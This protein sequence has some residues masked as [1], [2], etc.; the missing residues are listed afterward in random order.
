MEQIYYCGEC[1]KTFATPKILIKHLK[2]F[3]RLKVNSSFTCVQP[4]CK[5]AAFSSSYTFQKHLNTHQQDYEKNSFPNLNTNQEQIIETE[6]LPASIVLPEKLSSDE[7][8][9]GE[10]ETSEL[11][12][13]ELPLPSLSKKKTWQHSPEENITSF[14]SFLY[15]KTQISRKT[16]QE[17][18]DATSDFLESALNCLSE[19]CKALLQNQNQNDYQE[20]DKLI[21]NYLKTFQAFTTE[22]KRLSLFSKAT[23]KFIPPVSV[24]I[25]S[26]MVK[27]NN[28]EINIISKVEVVPLRPTLKAF[29]EMPEMLATVLKYMK[30][31]E[32]SE[33]LYVSSFLSSR[34][35]KEIKTLFGGNIVIPMFL[36]FD[37]YETCNPLGSKKTKHKMGGVYLQLACL[38]PE[39]KSSLKNTFLAQIFRSSDRCH[40]GNARIFGVLIRLLKDLEENGIDFL[41][42]GQPIK[43]F[44]TVAAITGDNLGLNQILGFNTGFR[45]N[46]FCRF[47]REC[48]KECEHQT[49]EN[50]LALRTVQNYNTDSSGKINGVIEECVFNRLKGYHVVRNQI[51]DSMHDWE[52][53]ICRVIYPKIIN[54][55]INK[56]Y[57]T[58]ELL[59]SRI[60]NF[61]FPSNVPSPITEDQLKKNHIVMTASEMRS[62]T[63]FFCV[64]V[65]DRIPEN[66][67][68]WEFYLLA[69]EIIELISSD[70]VHIRSHIYL[71]GLID[72]FNSKYLILFNE[73]LKPKFHFLLHYPRTLAEMGPIKNFSSIRGEANHR[74]FKQYSNVCHNKRNLAHSLAL[75]H[76][77]EKFAYFTRAT[78]FPKNKVGAE[79]SDCLNMY[80]KKLS[81]CNITIDEEIYGCT[82]YAVVNNIKI[83]KKDVIQIGNDN[84]ECQFGLVRMIFY[85]LH[86]DNF[87]LVC[88]K[89]KTAFYDP[90]ICSYYV[91]ACD[92]YPNFFE[93]NITT[94]YELK[95]TKITQLP[96]G[97]C[98]VVKW[99]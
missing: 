15:G 49:K 23:N 81:E 92:D 97:D 73:T 76:Q 6:E 36:Y 94:F 65:G 54:N 78:P 40:F 79:C 51:P 38:P 75:K 84:Y 66:D 58:L 89:I 63:K 13:S 70:T 88:Q 53:G 7:I 50:F 48:R 47:C 21:R 19:K 80:K 17:V 44:F 3:H 31:E 87:K 96:N 27:K 34:R 4:G 26:K 86:S 9:V 25:G 43:I 37:D 72:E 64:L 22:K 39:Y 68:V 85:S 20:I 60:E 71:S 8:D 16:I 14:I 74:S 10:T 45:G 29:F 61:C 35:W 5:A 99:H 11:C 95:A 33:E 90:H 82:N 32:E 77:L 67:E 12:S 46:H 69:R 83:E 24:E 30:S 2:F 98:V 1:N 59:N 56:N 55:F 52:D 62:F 28:K 91:A 42:E 18:V 41:F 93:L 57:F